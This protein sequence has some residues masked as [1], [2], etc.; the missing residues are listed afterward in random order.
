MKDT[1]A[2]AAPVLDVTQSGTGAQ[3]GTVVGTGTAVDPIV[4]NS[5]GKVTIATEAGAD[6]RFS[7][8]GGSTWHSGTSAGISS[9]DLQEGTN[10]LQIVQIDKAGNASPATSLTIVKDTVAPEASHLAVVGDLQS[11]I[12]ASGSIAIG[13]LEPGATWDYSLDGGQTWVH[14]QNASLDASVLTKGVNH[15]DVV[16]ID[17]AGNRGAVSSLDVFKPA[18]LHLTAATGV[19]DTVDGHLFNLNTP[20]SFDVGG[21]R[22]IDFSASTFTMWLKGSSVEASVL[23]TKAL[24]TTE[25]EVLVGKQWAGF[26]SE[27]SE[28]WDCVR[29]KLTEQADGRVTVSMISESGYVLDIGADR[30]TGPFAFENQRYTSTPTSGG[31]G[32]QAVTLS[33]RG[34]VVHITSPEQGSGWQYSTDDGVTWTTG[35]GDWLALDQLPGTSTVRLAPLDADGVRGEVT[36]LNRDG[37]EVVAA[38]ASPFGLTSPLDHL[39]SGAEALPTD[40][41]GHG[42]SSATDGLQD[43]SLPPPSA[44]ALDPSHTGAVMPV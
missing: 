11:G 6:W 16:Q 32:L 28:W 7:T 27:T 13:S 8:D 25:M 35:H 40:L 12:S 21:L 5:A 23:Y 44:Y 43:S 36:M 38:F 33:T 37:S 9:N 15:I 29:M 20:E 17:A 26:T 39:L 30:G 42:T 10:T 24:S 3:T 22:F 14:G 4:I 34:D 18:P 19:S 2:P 31:I 1:A 41:T